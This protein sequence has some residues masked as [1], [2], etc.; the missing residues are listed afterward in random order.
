MPLGCEVVA[1]K[2]Q[3]LGVRGRVVGPHTAED[4]ASTRESLR[5]NG[6]QKEQKTVDVEFSIL[7]PEAP[8]GR[9]IAESVQEDYFP[10]R[11]V[12]SSLRISPSLLGK[13]VGMV[14]VEPGRHD[15]GLNLKKNGQYH[16]LGYVRK[17]V[18]TYSNKRNHTNGGDAKN[19]TPKAP[20]SVWGAGDS[21]QV[22][23]SVNTERIAEA[24]STQWEY[25]A[26]ALALLFEYK[27]RF[28]LMFERLDNLPHQM[29]YQST[30][31]FVPAGMQ[32]KDT[33]AYATAAAKEV[34]EWLKNQS[35]FNMARTPLTTLSLSKYVLLYEHVH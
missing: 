29:K 12:C 14:L 30:D 25:S 4:S 5:A 21:V 15:F 9:A 16:L 13:I 2:G 3:L 34:E 27:N 22:V 1:I 7:P 31:V 24:E 26:K 28:P 18:D 35:F 20:A 8:F 19:E 10:S 11:D 6:K 17:V 32:G 33:S 23:G